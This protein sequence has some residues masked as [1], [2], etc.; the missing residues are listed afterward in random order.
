[1]TP[2]PFCGVTPDGP[3]GPDFLCPSCGLVRGKAEPAPGLKG[4]AT[5]VT[6]GVAV[7]ADGPYIPA[8]PLTVQMREDPQGVDVV[9]RWRDDLNLGGA[10]VSLFVAVLPFAALRSP[11]PWALLSLPVAALLLYHFAT[12]LVNSTTVRIEKEGIA[13]T[14]GP[15]PTWNKDVVLP[16]ARVRGVRVTEVVRRTF[17]GG[18]W[19]TYHLDAQGTRLTGWWNHRES[20]EYLR[21]VIELKT[22]G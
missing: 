19:T 5:G 14:N 22:A 6:L 15:L 3:L 2:C 8:P 17:R 16:A 20:L 21:K 10:V 4:G 18:R 7:P 11:S 9:L 1:M 12:Y 13:L